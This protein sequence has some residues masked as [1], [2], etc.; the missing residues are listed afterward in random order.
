MADTTSLKTHDDLLSDPH[1]HKE[2]TQDQVL[3]KRSQIF[4]D[5]SIRLL[6]QMSNLI[7]LT[8]NAWARFRDREVAYFSNL[9]KPS[10]P[11]R[12]PAPELWIV[13]I[14]RDIEDLRALRQ[15]LDHQREHLNALLQKVTPF[16]PY[17]LSRCL[18]R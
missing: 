16:D 8:L 3:S 5:K 10:A 2:D 6:Q 7:T 9:E 15:S 11:G 12:H 17:C 18:H 13:E 14:N 1:D 4:F